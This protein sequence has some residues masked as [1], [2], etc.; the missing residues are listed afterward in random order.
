[1]MKSYVVA[2]P[3]RPMVSLGPSQEHHGATRCCSRMALL[4]LSV[5]WRGHTLYLMH[6][7]RRSA[8]QL[9]FS[10]EQA[11]LFLFPGK[12]LATHCF[13]LWHLTVEKQY[14]MSSRQ[15]VK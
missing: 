9:G 5:A 14:Y 3:T 8:F 12:M 4:T 15:E 2:M 1:M 6:L 13:S 7:E 11:R 10:T